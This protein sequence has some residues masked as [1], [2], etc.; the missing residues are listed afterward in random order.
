MKRGSECQVKRGQ[1]SQEEKSGVGPVWCKGAKR[2][3]QS[4]FTAKVESGWLLL[5]RNCFC[6][7]VV[8]FLDCCTIQ[9]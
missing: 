5:K 4:L 1:E 2:E 9:Y 3:N 7:W 6:E 8:D